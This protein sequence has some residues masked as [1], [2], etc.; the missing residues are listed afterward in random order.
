MEV[1][2][3]KHCRNNNCIVVYGGPLSGN[4]PSLP[5]SSFP[6]SESSTGAGLA[7]NNTGTETITLRNANSNIIDR[8]QYAGTMLSDSGSIS[9]FPTLNDWFVPQPWIS[10]NVST[11][12]LQYDG[13]A[14]DQPTKI[15]V[16]GTLLSITYGDPV[17]LTFN[18]STSAATTLWKADALPGPFRPVDGKAFTSSAG[19]FYLSNPPSPHQFY[20][21]SAQ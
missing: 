9:R 8:I 4:S 19:V 10:T 17:V 15:P 5:V 13:G 1:P 16:P 2:E 11:A 7:L 20:G 6:A 18:A 14:W 3:V 21:I 12:G